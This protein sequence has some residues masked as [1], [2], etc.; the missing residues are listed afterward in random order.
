MARVTADTP[1]TAVTPAFP[2]REIAG[3]I[4]RIDSRVDPTSRT[5]R[6]RAAFDNAD[7]TLRP[8]M[9]FFITVRLP[10]P[11]VPVVPELALQWRAGE[12]YVWRIKDGAAEKVEVRSLRRRDQSILVDGD[13]SPGDLVV[14]EGVQRLRPGRAVDMTAADA[15][16]SGG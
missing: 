8:G 4:R 9:S 2:D 15:V 12:S 16:G 6:V 3:T 10:G 13:L 5:V 1:V 7:D 14:V 11:M